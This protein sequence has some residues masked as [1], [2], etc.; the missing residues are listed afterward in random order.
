MIKNIVFLFPGQGSQYK[1]MG[2]DVYEAYSSARKVFDTADHLLGFA[3][4]QLIFEG[5]EEELT[6]TKNSQVA[7]FV[8]SMALLEVFREKHPEITPIACAGL[9]LGEYAALCAA[10]KISFADC[11]MLV[12]ARGLFMQE[13]SEKYPGGLSAVLGLEAEDVETIIKDMNTEVWVA[14]LNCPKQVVI[15]GTHQGLKAAEEKL[16]AAGAK[17]V[18]PLEVSG[19]FHSGLMKEAQEKLK[20]K[21]H[22]VAFVD[23]P[24]D[25]VMNV[26]GD[27]VRE[28]QEIKKNLIL[29]VASPTRWEKGIR[30]IESKPIDFYLEIG[31][32][33]SLCGM[34]KKIGTAA[35]T[36]NLEKL[37]DFEKIDHILL[38]GIAS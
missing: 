34:N 31:C 18:L 33:K 37:E 35:P 25:V 38:T 1:G 28:M 22:Q 12:R 3:L 23:T 26:P 19:A 7:I 32:G 9:S 6:L 21:I 15:S 30:L 17:R 14:N 5:P 11:L 4:S 24:V 29:Q 10:G 20:E 13:A 8:T 27:C 16:K 2:H 36:Y